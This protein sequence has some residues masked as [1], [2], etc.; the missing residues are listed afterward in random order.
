MPLHMISGQSV[1]DAV[2]LSV[3]KTLRGLKLMQ[4]IAGIFSYVN[5]CY[6]SASSSSTSRVIII[7]S[8]SRTAHESC[9]YQVLLYMS[10]SPWTVHR[11]MACSSMQQLT[12]VIQTS[13]SHSCVAQPQELSDAILKNK[14]IL[15]THFIVCFTKLPM[16]ALEQALSEIYI[17]RIDI[18][19]ILALYVFCMS[20]I[21]YPAAWLHVS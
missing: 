13:F 12:A 9:I 8:F 19:C 18:L 2:S 21:F 7:L 20:V 5:K 17:Q 3:G 14:L 16:N 1:D 10:M 11:R 4:S 6:S 15:K